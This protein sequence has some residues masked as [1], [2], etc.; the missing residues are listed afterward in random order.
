MFQWDIMSAIGHMMH[1]LFNLSQT[2][3]NNI[4]YTT[5]TIMKSLSID[6]TTQI[7]SLLKLG[8]SIYNIYS[9]TGVHPS[10]ISHIYSKHCPDLVKPSA[11]HPSIITPT[12]I[13]SFWALER[14]KILFKLPKHSRMSRT[15]P[16][17]PRPF[18]ITLERLV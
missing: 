14:L 12:D 4:V 7:I 2:H 17:P 3:P 6:Q 15:N 13:F 8:H 16:S 10:T 5:S 9:A 1:K 18:I 11:G